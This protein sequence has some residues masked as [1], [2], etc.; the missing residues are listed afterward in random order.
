[1]MIRD[2]TEENVGDYLDYIPMELLGEIKR[3]YW[4]GLAGTDDASG[5]MTAG[6][7][8]ELKNMEKED[9]PNEAEIMWFSSD[10]ASD[11]EELLGT[12]NESLKKDQVKRV[13]FELPSLSSEEE[14]ALSDFGYT[15]ESAE[16]RDI[17]VTAEE[18]SALKIA[19]KK[20]EDYVYPL[21]DIAPRQFKAGIMT[22][23]FHDRYGLLEDLP[24]LPMTR[25]DPDISCCIQTD[26]SVDGFLLVHK[27]TKGPFRVELFS[28]M[29]P[30]AD[31]H[32]LNMMRF[33]AQALARLETPDTKVLL[34]RH[35]KGSTELIKKLF[36]G[37][38]GETVRRGERK[39]K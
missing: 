22:C 24:F 13:F 8:W 21:S 36:P 5:S 11:G 23:I 10:D 28:A 37:K 9:E 18:I 4:R 17:Y 6:V 39:V 26:G 34:R 7:L 3:E 20:P 38:K 31:I 12:L 1:M 30:D 2:I 35:H 16:S 29:Q 32:L 25:F 27:I 14:K 15:L 19:K 33:A